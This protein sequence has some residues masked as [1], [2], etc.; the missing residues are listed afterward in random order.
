MATNFEKQNSKFVFEK[1]IPKPARIPPQTPPA[2]G[3][4]V[5]A[6]RNHSPR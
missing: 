5:E 3:K 1:M 4:S 2:G 6:G